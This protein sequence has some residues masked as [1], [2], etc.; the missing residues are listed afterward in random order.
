MDAVEAAV[1]LASA[2][3]DAVAVALAVAVA[4]AEA[5]AVAVATAAADAEA[6]SC[7]VEPLLAEAEAEDAVL[8]DDSVLPFQRQICATKSL[9]VASA[10]VCCRISRVCWLSTEA[11]GRPRANCTAHTLNVAQN[12]WSTSFLIIT[13]STDSPQ[14][15]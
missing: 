6:D 3:D 10:F 12:S 5:V 2:V 13:R 7:P 1:A 11:K 14:H 15:S 8:P 9:P 4:V